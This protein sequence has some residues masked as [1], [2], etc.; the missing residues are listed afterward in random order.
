MTGKYRVGETALIVVVPEAEPVV[1]GWRSRFD[2]SAEA[3][4][5]AHVTVLYPFLDQDRLDEQ[6]LEVLLGAH[7]PFDVRFAGCGRFPGV[8]FL[9]PLP[10]QPFRALT[11]AVAERWP[12]APPY[13]GQFAE[14]I[15]HL[16]VVTGQEPS[17]LDE[18][19]ADLAVRLPVAA[20]V[21]AVRLLVSDGDRWHSRGVFALRGLCTRVLAQE[22]LCI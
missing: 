6:S 7:P 14:T 16:T 5:P 2:P 17:V 15:P 21:A 8:L 1:G 11:E 18:V 3:G 22:F 4:V 9:A 20:H 12:E 10:D 13:G 19:E